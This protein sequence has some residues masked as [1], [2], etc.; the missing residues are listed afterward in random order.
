MLCGAGLATVI[1]GLAVSMLPAAAAEAPAA[2][3]T[4]TVASN[5]GATS[6][7][8]RVDTRSGGRFAL[9]D[10][11]GQCLAAPGGATGVALA[12]AACDTTA[13]DQQWSFVA[14]SGAYQLKNGQSG[15]CAR[16][17]ATPALDACTGDA[18][19][20]WTFTKVGGGT[21]APAGL[22][23]WAAQNGTTTGGAGGAT[24]TVTTAAQ[25]DSALQ[26]SGA[27]IVKVS[28]MIAL[29]GMH[30]V[31]SNKTIQGVGSGSGLRG[32]GLTLDNVSNVIIQNLNITG[33]GDDAV[34]VQ[35]GSHHVWIDHNTLSDAY[36][37]LVDIRLGS[38]YVTVSWNITRDHDKTMLLGSADTDT[39]D[40]GHLRV[41]Y[42]HNWFDGTNQRHPRVRF[43]NP[44]HVYNNLYSNNGA[45]GVASTMEAGVLVEGNYFDHVAHPTTLAQGTSPDGNLVQRDNYFTGSGT[46]MTKGSVKAI[47]YAYTMDAASAVKSIVSAGA[48]TGRL[49]L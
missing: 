10:T 23:G 7:Q 8:W 20:L 1:A 18:N 19:R 17:G 42:H 35:N 27:R 15:W 43:G 34:N 3:N 25:L 22:V 36:D 40:R 46:P 33:S 30:K 13:A 24:V 31:S 45:Y 5:D 16:S 29:T 26:A 49:G 38:D 47:P 9:V 4:Y 37:G 12:P 11:A 28:G 2:G 39:G 6:R 32:G 44:V 48:G 41:T 21:P 14:K